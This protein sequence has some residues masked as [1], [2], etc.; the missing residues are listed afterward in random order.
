MITRIFIVKIKQALRTEFEERFSTTS[1]SVVRNAK[2]CLSEQILRPA[3]W[4]PNEYAM[5]SVWENELALNEFVGD[6]WSKA[7]IPAGME[8]FVEDCW[9]HHF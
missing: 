8:K 6:D 9:V 7:F 1:I 5:I 2:G 3:K 4:T